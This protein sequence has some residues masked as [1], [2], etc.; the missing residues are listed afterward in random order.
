[1]K[2]SFSHYLSEGNWHII[3]DGWDPKLQNVRESHFTIGNGYFASRGALDG[4]PY[5][6]YPGT[7][8]AGI[9]DN[10]GAQ[11]TELVNTPDPFY[12]KVISQGEKLDNIAMNVLEHKRILDMKKGLL[13]RKT[14]Y[15]NSKK[16]RFDYQSLRFISMGDKHLGAMSVALTPLDSSAAFTIESGVDTSV[17]NKGVLTE[18]RKKHFFI[19]EVSKAGNNIYV[20]VRTFEHN[21]LIGCG[22]NLSV[23]KGSKRINITTP[24]FKLKLKK[25][26]T[27]IFTKIFSVYTSRRIN[28]RYLK[29]TVLNAVRRNKKNGFE[30]LLKANFDT[31]IKRWNMADIAIKGDEDVEKALRFNIYHMLICA[32]ERE[33]AFSV[34]AKTLSGEGYRGHVFWDTE[35]FILPFFIYTFPRIARNLIMYRYC[36]LDAARK[37]AKDKNYKGALF[38][39]ESADSG[40]DVTPTWAKDLDGSIIEISTMHE[41]QHIDADI[42]YAVSQ[43]YDVTQDNKFFINNGAEILFATAKFWISRM[44]LNKKTKRY[45]INNIMG[46]DEF[47]DN[48]NNNTYTN[49]M[50]RWNLIRAYGAYTMLKSKRHT[51]LKKL[52]K[53]TKLKESDIRKWRHIAQRIKIPYSKKKK[54]IEAFDGYFRLKD[55]P[56]AALDKNF[57]PL[58]PLQITPRNVRK[59]Q[60]IK[61]ADTVMLLYLLTE[62][63]SLKEK[64]RN[65]V[66]YEKRTLHKSSLSVCTHSIIASEI[67][68]K[69]KAYL[70]FH[71]S[72]MTD[73]KNIH[74]NTAD[75]IH[76]ASLGGTWQIVINGFAGMRIK[77][78][79]IHFNPNLPT[80]WR[81]IKFK[82]NWRGHILHIS[83]FHDKIHIFYSCKQKKDTVFIRVYGVLRQLEPNVLNEFYKE[84]K[85]KKR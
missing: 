26:E 34:G 48:V 72:L 41:E 18:G 70:Y 16:E 81:E 13:Y 84:R 63:F 31:W 57:M 55:V 58:F 85:R 3:E 38:P 8:I 60:L 44:Q 25:G 43:Y 35:I 5:D 29:R 78:K 21:I 30:K 66:Y 47:H 46:P 51:L 73:L 54:L 59:T 42:A 9:F 33:G 12:F 19:S 36:R 4:N 39:W 1:M 14:L 11:V 32:P 71:N 24:I 61:Q 17:T 80:K 74:N 69:E 28:A 65:Y 27:A 76:A 15:S 64:K 62:L 83:V 79:T 53:K 77:K 23:T 52:L 49:M 82:M 2:D 68:H 22:Y 40:L 75:G 37:I 67:G 20:S 56:I 6:A 10:T 45:E 50:V 7:Y